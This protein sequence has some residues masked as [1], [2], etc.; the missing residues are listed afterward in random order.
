M[1]KERREAKGNEDDLRAKIAEL[2]V[3]THLTAP[4]FFLPQISGD[5]F[6]PLTEGPG[7]C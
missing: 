4:E 7:G 5:H 3:H 1:E 6:K 2:K